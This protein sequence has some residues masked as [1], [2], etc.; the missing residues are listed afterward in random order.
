MAIDHRGEVI[1]GLPRG[2]A[3]VPQ[4]H[5]ANSTESEAL[6][7]IE[8]LGLLIRSERMALAQ[9][10]HTRPYQ[11]SALDLLRHI[12]KMAKKQTP[13]S[14]GSVIKGL[15]GENFGYL[16]FILDQADLKRVGE[17]AEGERIYPNRRIA[18]T[19]AT[20]MSS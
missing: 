3:K 6:N 8:D 14:I 4:D 20:I 11:H 18:R 12:E 1:E 13:P 10:T 19:A 15:R 17:A 9:I 7:S 16:R 5:L 2:Y